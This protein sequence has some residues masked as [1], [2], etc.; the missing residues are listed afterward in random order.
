MLGFIIRCVYIEIVRF[1][2][3]RVYIEMVGLLLDV[4]ILR[5][6]GYY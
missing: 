6:W 3:R 2:I 5:W 4:F 1:I